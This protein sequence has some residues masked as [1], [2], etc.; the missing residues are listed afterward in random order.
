MS[1]R[2]EAS[3][4][5]YLNACGARL[6][7]AA[8][9]D[10]SA[11]RRGSRNQNDASQM[12]ISVPLARLTCGVSRIRVRVTVMVPL[13]AGTLILTQVGSQAPSAAFAWLQR[14]CKELPKPCCPSFA[15]HPQRFLRCWFVTKG[16]VADAVITCDIHD[17]VGHADNQGLR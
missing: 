3:S 7:C 9:K 2:V 4:G 17:S 15:L 16:M 12:V 11:L 14:V 10:G 8:G 6:L 5:K 1:R 13:P